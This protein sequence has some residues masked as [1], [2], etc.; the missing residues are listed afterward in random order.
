M[1]VG[2]VAIG[3]GLGLAA[4]GAA[5]LSGGGLLATLLMIS[6]T[7]TLGMLSAMALSAQ[8]PDRQRTD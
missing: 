1:F 5:A 2:I 3:L 7:G 4:G 8:C 6:L